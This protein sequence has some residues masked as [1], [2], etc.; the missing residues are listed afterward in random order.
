MSEI[1]FNKQNFAGIILDQP[2]GHTHLKKIFLLVQYP[3]KITLNID[4]VSPATPARTTHV[5]K[6]KSAFFSVKLCDFSVKLCVSMI[7]KNMP[8]SL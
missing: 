6:V 3:G 1:Y 7:F 4:P 2:G 8:S 5:S